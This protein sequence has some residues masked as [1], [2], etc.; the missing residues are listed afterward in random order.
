M[1]PPTTHEETM[2]LL[3]QSYH[4]LLAKIDEVQET[5]KKNKD[6]AE[7]TKA[8]KTNKLIRYWFENNGLLP[9]NM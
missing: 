9:K 7:S 4:D 8:H 6:D 5:L 1:I 2:T 3:M